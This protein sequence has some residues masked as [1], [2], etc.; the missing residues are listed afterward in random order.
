MTYIRGAGGGKGGG[1][2]SPTEADDSLQSIQYATVLDLLSE[3]EI[4]GLDDG[5]KSIYLG[6]TPIQDS[7]GANNFEGYTV[8][9]RNG[10][11]SQAYISSLEGTESESSVNVKVENG[12]PVVRQI[13]NTNTDRVRLTLRIPSLRKVEDDGDIVGNS[14]QIKIEAQ[15]NGGGYSTVK[16]DTIVGKSSNLYMRDYVFSLSGAFPVDIRFTRVSADD[17]DA[18]SESQIFWS[19]YTEIID[20]KL[21]YP[22][23]ALAYLRFDSRQFNNIPD[24]KYKIRGIKV[25]LP[26]NATVDT[27]THIG[28]VTYSG[29][30]NGTFGAAT[31]CNDPAWCLYDLLISSRYGCSIPE[32]S[33]DKW[34]FYSISQYCNELVDD[35]KGSQEPRFACN[36]LINQRKDVYTV[37]KEMASL[38]RGLSY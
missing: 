2:G 26:S 1:G 8:H 27:T 35:R 5:Y 37:V 18:K 11:Q 10:V 31:W 19:S 12:S 15:Y 14:V 38:F 7:S 9:T 32:S 6:G 3:G 29:V 34:D 36:I 4:G 24:R 21:T 16:T 22:N 13:T 30:W 17:P 25:K 23:S 33:L 28:R 20:E